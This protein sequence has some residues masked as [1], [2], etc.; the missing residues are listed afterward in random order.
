MGDL[1]GMIEAGKMDPSE[2]ITHTMPLDNALKGYDI[3]HHRTDGC[4]KVLLKP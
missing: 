4:V 1:L 3:F 2:I